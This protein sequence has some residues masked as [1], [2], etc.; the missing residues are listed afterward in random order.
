MDKNDLLQILLSVDEEVELSLG[1]LSPKPCV[2]IVGGAAFFLNDATLRKVTHDI[3]IL[4]ADTALR[5]ILNKYPQINFAVNAYVNNLPY[6]FEDQLITLDIG[7][8]AV[9]YAIVSMEDLAIMKLYAQRPHDMQDLKSAA[10]NGL[11]N[12]DLLEHL[13]YAQ[14]EAKAS[15]LSEKS[16]NE[17]VYAYEKFKKYYCK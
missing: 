12:W 6:N 7:A 13:A 5:N 3:D 17:M 4:E 11:L 10:E 9:N 2:V 15:A 8:R 16:Y 14:D 1:I